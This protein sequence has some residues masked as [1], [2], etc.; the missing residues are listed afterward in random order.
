MKS[1][2][3][4]TIFKRLRPECCEWLRRPATA[5]S[6]LYSTLDENL[7][8]LDTRDSFIKKNDI[9]DLKE[10][11][12]PIVDILQKFHC[13]YNGTVET[14]D[15]K[16]FVKKI[17]N[18]TSS[19]VKKIHATVEVG[20]ALY[21]IRIHMLVVHSLLKSQVDMLTLCHLRHSLTQS[22]KKQRI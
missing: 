3:Q 17:L 7:T 9:A 16:K 14:S 12:S 6:E 13:D 15:A 11:L 5:C 20:G 22:L 1:V 21:T 18:L 4:D 10:S 8:L 19:E 2:D